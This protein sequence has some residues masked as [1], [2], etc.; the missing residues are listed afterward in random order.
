LAIKQYVAPT[1]PGTPVMHYTK[2]RLTIKEPWSF[3]WAASTGVNNNSPLR[4]HRFILSRCP[5][6]SNTFTDLTGL[7]C[8]DDDTFNPV[9]HGSN[10]DTQVLVENTR[11]VITINN[12]ADLGFGPGDKVQIK[13]SA[14]TRDGKNN[15]VQSAYIPS[16]EYLVQNAGI[17]NVNVNGDWK[18]GQVWVNINGDWK[19]A[20]SVNVNTDGVWKESQ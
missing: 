15:I 10:A 16:A 12:P 17:V 20:E 3:S 5:A 2:S 8:N 14:F 7:K 1:D 9:A 6:G 4:G 18:E 13:V 19:E 11:R